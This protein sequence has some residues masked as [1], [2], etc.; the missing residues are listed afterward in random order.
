MEVI[1]EK[2]TIV[3]RLGREEL[4]VKAL[5]KKVPFRRIDF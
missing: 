1:K 4:I 3:P 2:R 5:K